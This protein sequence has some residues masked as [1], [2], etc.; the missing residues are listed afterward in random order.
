MV[1]ACVCVCVC[2][3]DSDT[4]VGKQKTTGGRKEYNIGINFVLI[5]KSSESSS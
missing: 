2:V 4:V 5:L 1:C 3:S